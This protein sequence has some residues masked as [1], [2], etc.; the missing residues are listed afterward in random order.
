M[1]IALILLAVFAALAFTDADAPAARQT[2]PQGSH[3]DDDT[4]DACHRDDFRRDSIS[5]RA[6][7]VLHRTGESVNG[8]TVGRRRA[9]AC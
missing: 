9:R 7:R 2:S 4:A 6:A 8:R 1:K 3:D 5:R